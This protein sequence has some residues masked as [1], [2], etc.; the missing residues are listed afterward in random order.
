VT[1][2]RERENANGMN[3]QKALKSRPPTCNHHARR[4]RLNR[5]LGLFEV[6]DLTSDLEILL[7]R[8]NL[9]NEVAQH[10][11]HIHEKDLR[12]VQTKTPF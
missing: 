1:I 10:S 9:T 2:V 4:N 12:S 11:R 6:C 5:S 7:V 3:A 8:N